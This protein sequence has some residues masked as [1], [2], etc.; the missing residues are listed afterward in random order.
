M[1]AI[2]S[3][4]K[5]TLSFI[6]STWNIVIS[7]IVFVLAIWVLQKRPHKSDKPKTAARG[8]GVVLLA[9]ALSSGSGVLV[10]WA[11]VKFGG[12]QPKPYLRQLLEQM[13]EDAG[14]VLPE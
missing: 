7:S 14:I 3:L 12:P 13:I 1:Q 5:M 9:F 11:L 10:D 2:E 6:P 8:F 4:L